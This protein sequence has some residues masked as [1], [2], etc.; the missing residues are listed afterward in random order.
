MTAAGR[1]GRDDVTGRWPRPLALIRFRTVRRLAIPALLML[2]V[3]ALVL[4]ACGDD[5]GSGAGTATAE[6]AAD[7][8]FTTPSGATCSTRE[9]DSGGD[10]PTYSEPPPLNLEEGAVYTATLDTSCGEIVIELD[11]EGA[12]ITVNNFVFL[13][14][15]GFYDGLTFHRTVP[16]FVIQGGDPSGDG[17][18]GP[19]YEFEDELPDDG[20]PLGSVAMANAGPGTNGSQFFIVTGDAAA[21]TNDYSKFG[22]VVEGLEVA[23]AIESLGDEATQ[24]PSSPV[25]IYSITIENT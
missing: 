9:P 7:G 25:Y 2:L 21:L 15:E 18:G 12:P 11:A 19:G 4:S 22:Q 6:A 1:A 16:G 23:Q 13:A 20:Y 24:L 10:R 8:T 14:R 17:S 5:G 3:C